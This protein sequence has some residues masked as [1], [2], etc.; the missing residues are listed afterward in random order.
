MILEEYMQGYKNVSDFIKSREA[1]SGSSYDYEKEVSSDMYDEM[2]TNIKAV[3]QQSRAELGRFLN[4]P[5]SAGLTERQ[6]EVMIL[7]AGGSTF[8]E[9]GSL[10]GISKQAV[11]K[12]VKKSETK[13]YGMLQ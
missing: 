9:I 6:R 8:E 7:R 12:L 11:A 4:G 5:E 1:E 10:L 13:I 2:K 3:R